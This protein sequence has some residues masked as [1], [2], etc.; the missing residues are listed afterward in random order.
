MSGLLQLESYFSS[1]VHYFYSY[2][3]GLTKVIAELWEH[4]DTAKKK[5]DKSRH[6]VIMTDTIWANRKI[7]SKFDKTVST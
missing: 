6:N 4:E 3:I 2:I 5:S 7:R 1:F